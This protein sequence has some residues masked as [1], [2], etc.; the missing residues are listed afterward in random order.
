MED[1]KSSRLAEFDIETPL[2]LKHARRTPRSPSPMGKFHLPPNRSGLANSGLEGVRT[3]SLG[4][5]NAVLVFGYP[6]NFRDF[7]IDKFKRLGRIEEIRMS[8]GNWMNIVYEDYNAAHKA[9][10]FN[11]GY[12][13]EGVLIGVKFLGNR[14]DVG[15]E[16]VVCLERGGEENVQYLKKVP[17]RSAGVLEQFVRYVLNRD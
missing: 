15:G 13:A 16:R 17:R 3:E 4:K 12:I 11:F 5:E 1:R 14:G 10:A 7:V 6:E 9:L 2:V 8:E